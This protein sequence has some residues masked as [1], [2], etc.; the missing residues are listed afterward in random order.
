MKE[1][2]IVGQNY[3][4]L[5]ELKRDIAFELS[6]RGDGIKRLDN[7]V[8]NVNIDNKDRKIILKKS[9]DS[10]NKP[11]IIP[12][13]FKPF[14]GGFV[15]LE[16]PEKMIYLSKQDEERVKEGSLA[17][18]MANVYP[19]NC[20]PYDISKGVRVLSVFDHSELQ[21]GDMVFF[22]ATK[23][24]INSREDAQPTNR[25]QHE[26]AMDNFYKMTI[27]G[28]ECIRVPIQLIVGKMYGDEV[29]MREY[30]AETKKDA[31][32]LRVGM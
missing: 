28:V 2:K 31:Y 6:E 11:T 23:I 18:S 4:T 10:K 16:L 27:N 20:R 9:I 15:I 24:I 7:K 30:F 25:L 14:G 12:F 8:V 19:D 13:T 21:P 26:I 29:D 22:N 5:E 17:H 1:A 3:N 32:H